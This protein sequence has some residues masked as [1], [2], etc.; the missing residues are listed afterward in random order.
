MLSDFLKDSHVTQISF[1]PVIE[2]A[3]TLKKA[4]AIES[5]HAIYTKFV[6][7]ELVEALANMMTK[8]NS[9]VTLIVEGLPLTGPFMET[10]V[11]GLSNNKSIKTLSL[12]RSHIGDEACDSLC[13]TV[14]HLMNIETLNLSNTN[15]GIK[16]AETVA[17]MIKSQKIQ[18][19]SEAWTQ[20]LRYNNV[21]A[22]SFPGLRKILL[23]HNRLIGDDGLELL[24]EVFVEDVWIK[25]VE[26]QDCGLT[27]EGAQIIIKC[28]DLNKTIL[29][30]NISGNQVSDHLRRHIM[31]NLGNSDQESSESNG[32]PAAVKVTK[33]N[34]MEQV[35]FLQGRVETELYR[36]KKCEQLQDKLHKQL[37]D[38]QREIV[39][40]GAFR[41][42]D[43]FTLVANETLEKLLNE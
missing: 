34:L 8:N 15:L 5:Q 16:G 32:E 22:D 28:L 1:S 25:D 24:T 41:I 4:K 42:P 39:I 30:F 43:G 6:F 13:S 35:K 21:D 31:S 29:N 3:D 17:N 26:M 7:G 33:A 20:S 23:N 37:I 40:Q 38:Y 18:R 27:D 12:T 36:R 11:K 2:E 14:K 10:F 9:L 19:F